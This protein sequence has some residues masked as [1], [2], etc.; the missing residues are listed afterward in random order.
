MKNQKL[1]FT[2]IITLF[3]VCLIVGGVRE[4]YNVVLETTAQ[5]EETSEDSLIDAK[6]AFSLN[7]D[8]E[9]ILFE[10]NSD[11]EIAPASTA[12]LLTAITALDYCDLEDVVTIGEEVWLV[13]LDSSRAWI[14]PGNQFT[15]K[16][17][18]HAMLLPS[19]NDAAYALAIYAG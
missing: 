18:L 6:Y 1:M 3:I 12:K 14:D 7:L 8:K 13:A 2:K 16:Q 11:E 17:L 9:V 19:G 5:T 15:I 4:Y 10:K